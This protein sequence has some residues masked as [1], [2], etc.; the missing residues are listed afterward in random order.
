M[1]LNRM[2]EGRRTL[3]SPLSAL[4]S[5]SSSTVDVD[6]D[7]NDARGWDE[8]DDGTDGT[9]SLT[10]T[11][12]SSSSHGHGPDEEGKI[13][14]SCT[15]RKSDLESP[16]AKRTA[17]RILDQVLVTR[18]MKL[19]VHIHKPSSPDASPLKATWTGTHKNAPEVV[20]SQ[21]AREPPFCVKAKRRH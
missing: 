4:S 3:L 9:K 10:P 5:S 20:T 18:M 1:P 8:A 12:S 15:L 11:G 7:D 6:E 19:Q 21:S 16:C 17:L 2:E 13:F 14:R